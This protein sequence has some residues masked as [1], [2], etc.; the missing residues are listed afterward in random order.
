MTSV[1]IIQTY[2]T[3]TSL[4]F[5]AI[6][7]ALRGRSVRHYFGTTRSV[8]ESDGLPAVQGKCM[9]DLYVTCSTEA[10][11]DGCTLDLYVRGNGPFSYLLALTYAKDGK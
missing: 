9:T 7:L 6:F 2:T 8:F 10:C 1:T 4:N 11:T 5:P 3:K